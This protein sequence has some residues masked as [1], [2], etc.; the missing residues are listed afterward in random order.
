MAIARSASICSVT[1]IV[2]SSAAIEA[3]TRPPTTSAVSTG[4]SSMITERRSPS[5]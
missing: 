4:P 2:P 5:R 1:F 3:P